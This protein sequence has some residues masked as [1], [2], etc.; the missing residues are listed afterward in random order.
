MNSI[1]NARNQLLFS[2]LKANNFRL[3]TK[4]F[5]SQTHG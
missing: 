2:V 1:N 5:N 3:R 4:N